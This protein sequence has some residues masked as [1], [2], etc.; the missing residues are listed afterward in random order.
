M[1][2]L[3]HMQQDTRRKELIERLYSF[4]VL[5]LK[6]Q[7]LET[8]SIE[9]LEHE[10]EKLQHDCHPHSGISSIQWTHSCK[11]KTKHKALKCFD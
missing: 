7:D 4:D 8:M 6:R 10:F 11:G 2:H 3:A 5:N 9:K 1:S